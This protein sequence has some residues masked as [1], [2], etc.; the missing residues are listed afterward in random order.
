MY[1]RTVRTYMT[2]PR[3]RGAAVEIFT[4]N[5]FDIFC[6]WFFVLHSALPY[7]ASNR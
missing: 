7:I 2:S 4:G 1:V 5:F 3:K 6:L